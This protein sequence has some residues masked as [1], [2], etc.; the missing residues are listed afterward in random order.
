ML[1]E[2]TGKDGIVIRSTFPGPEESEPSEKT[3]VL[4][5]GSFR[6][7]RRPELFIDLAARLPQYDFVMVGGPW[8]SEDSIFTEMVEKSKSVHNLQMTGPVPY[9][10]VGRYFSQAKVFVNTSSAEGFPNTYLQAWCR[11]VPVVATFDADTLIAGY[12]LGKFCGS[13]DDL[14]DGVEQYMRDDALRAS[15]GHA[16]IKYV[17]E[18]H[19]LDAVAGKYDEL[20]V[21]LYARK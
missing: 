1:K 5:V 19:S 14:V 21:R 7:V 9:K 6:E 18:Q 2:N 17:Q 16:A 13:L 20:F 10:E 3:C 11:G 4:W 15:V 8:Q 12:G